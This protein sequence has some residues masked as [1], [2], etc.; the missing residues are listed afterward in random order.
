IARRCPL[1][2]ETIT[3]LRE[4]LTKRPQAK[5]PADAGLVFLSQRGT[6]LV[7]IREGNRTDGVAVQFANLLKKLGIQRASVGFYTLRHVFRSA[8]DAA[9]DPVAIDL[10]MGHADPSIGGHYRERI[11]DSRLRAVAAHVH[12]WLFGNGPNDG[13]AEEADRPAA[14]TSELGEL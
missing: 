12:E 9:R 14:E 10:M 11:D 8:A 6:P 5:D 4:A 13:G 3:A 7:C 1:W 2:P